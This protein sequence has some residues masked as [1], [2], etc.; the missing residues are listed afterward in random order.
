MKI[1]SVKQQANTN[2]M[3]QNAS[4]KQN[5]GTNNVSFGTRFHS[6]IMNT[7]IRNE[8]EIS[9][10]LG[11]GSKDIEALCRDIYQDGHPERVLTEGSFGRLHLNS[12]SIAMLTQ[13]LRD[14]E[15]N[16]GYN[17]DTSY[18]TTIIGE[19]IKDI[20]NVLRCGAEGLEEKHTQVIEKINGAIE[21]ITS[22]KLEKKIVQDEASNRASALIKAM[23]G[24]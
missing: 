13:R 15:S 1:A 22:R 17:H 7:I 11:K 3:S 21:R 23:T 6:S 8:G 4:V 2:R 24:K 10:Y 12:D 18:K 9:A 19:G 20:A 16:E 14:I 5:N